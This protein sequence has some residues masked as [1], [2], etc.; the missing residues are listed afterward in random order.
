MYRA[1]QTFA[2]N[3]NICVA[4][5]VQSGV[6]A[7]EDDLCVAGAP[8][9]AIRKDARVAVDGLTAAHTGSLIWL[10]ALVPNFLKSNPILLEDRPTALDNEALNAA[11]ELK[12]RSSSENVLTGSLLCSGRP[13]KLSVSSTLKLCSRFAMARAFRASH[14]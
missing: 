6:R 7:I 2:A 14:V 4:F 12:A 8:T 3:I 11:L 1:K 9:L 10:W 5:R 13:R